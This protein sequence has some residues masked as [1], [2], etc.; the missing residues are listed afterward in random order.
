[1][2]AASISTTNLPSGLLGNHTYSCALP[3]RGGVCNCQTGPQ[4]F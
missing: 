2:T 1:M 3:A 4:P